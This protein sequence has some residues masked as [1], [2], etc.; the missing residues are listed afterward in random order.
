MRESDGFPA[1]AYEKERQTNQ[2]GIR[3]HE[4]EEAEKDP[5]TKQRHPQRC[6]HGTHADSFGADSG[7]LSPLPHAPL[8]WSLARLVA[9]RGGLVTPPLRLGVHSTEIAGHSQHK[10]RAQPHDV[11]HY[12]FHGHSPVMLVSDVPP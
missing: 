12:R 4:E 11:A 5:D 2:C 7:H 10:K 9:W 8:S 6:L 1:P 3:G